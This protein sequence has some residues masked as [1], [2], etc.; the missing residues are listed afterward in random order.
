MEITERGPPGT[1]KEREEPTPALRLERT[2]KLRRGLR[3]R[4][5]LAR[6]SAPLP[7]SEGSALRV[8]SPH[9]TST[10]G[11]P[12]LPVRV[13]GSRFGPYDLLGPSRNVLPDSP[14][15]RT[16]TTRLFIGPSNQ[17]AGPRPNPHFS[18]TFSGTFPWARSRH[19]QP[20]RG[21][22]EDIYYPWVAS[23]F[24]RSEFVG[25]VRAKRLRCK[26]FCPA[27]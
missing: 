24:G 23:R 20:V 17:A 21:K 22:S 14:D 8:G 3:P 4:E 7:S 1:A 9:F 11:T 26:D 27:G 13:D 16:L 6:R 19:P 12:R 25:V 15:Y 5:T 18:G 2:R 10:R